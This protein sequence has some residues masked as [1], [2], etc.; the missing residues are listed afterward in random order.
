MT[1][2][3]GAGIEPRA[4]QRIDE[5]LGRHDRATISALGVALVVAC[6]YADRAAGPDVGLLAYVAP[7][8]LVGWYAGLAPAVAIAVVSAA[9]TALARLPSG[10]PAGTLLAIGGG[11]LARLGVL[12]VAAWTVTALRA[13][14]RRATEWVR[15]DPLTGI[16]NLRGFL[17][18]AALEVA[19]ARRY[20][21]PFTVVCIDLDGFKA[22]ND[23]FGHAAGDEVLRAVASGLRD[24]L[25]AT[26]IVARV[27]GDRF[28]VLLPETSAAPAR[29]VIRKMQDV[30]TRAATERW[31]GGLTSGIGAATYFTPP[32][33]LESLI[34][35]GDA[36]VYEAKAAGPNAVH[37]R[38]F[39]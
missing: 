14:R 10:A 12:L 2:R 21:H 26:D 27:E 31:A 24:L 18:R 23:R 37:H 25:R 38:T 28:V 36:L 17:E 35:S 33:T 20:T 32:E 34:Q 22:I 8:A 9:V 19:R 15:T 30:L 3:R 13:A 39:N 16:P 6:A 7:V 5:W 11:A 1:F 29:L 4:W